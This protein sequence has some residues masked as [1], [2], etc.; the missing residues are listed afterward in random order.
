MMVE[1]A[2]GY[3]ERALVGKILAIRGQRVLLDADLAA[4][5]GVST[6]ALNQA[7]KRNA[8]RF[9]GDFAFQLT[10]REV[11]GMRSQTVTASKRNV[12][13]RPWVFTEHGALM[14][15]A[16]LNSRQAVQMSLFVVRAFVRL[17]RVAA[18]HGDLF[19]KLDEL[20]RRV[21]AHDAQLRAVFDALR[22]LMMEPEKPKK[23][24][25][26]IVEEKGITYAGGVR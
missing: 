17:R 16:V 4:V 21:G 19:R 24:I 7:V 25:G 18:V 15:A 1:E 23:R 11:S 10:A 8:E 14:A 20:E 5:Y 26:F 9:P 6:K 22:R 3:V 2:A 13:H 12:R